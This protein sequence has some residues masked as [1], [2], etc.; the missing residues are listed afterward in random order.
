LIELTPARSV[1]AIS[2]MIR[3]G[4]EID[5]THTQLCDNCDDDCA[6]IFHVAK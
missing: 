3:F 5:R 4:V 1:F 6:K 2:I